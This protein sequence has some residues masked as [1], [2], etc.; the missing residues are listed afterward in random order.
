[1]DNSTLITIALAGVILVPIILMGLRNPMVFFYFSLAA[2]SFLKTPE[3]PYVREKLAA[4]EIGL[5]LVWLFWG[6]IPKSRIEQPSLNAVYRYGGFF[7]LI[8]FLSTGLAVL[9]GSP[10]VAGS[11]LSEKNV[12]Y[13][14]IEAMNYTY[15]VLIVWTT[16]RLLDSWQRWISAILAWMAGMAIASFIGAAAVAG[17]A[18]DWAF[19][20]TGRICSTLK[21]ENQVPSMILPII[22]AVLLTTVRTG[23]NFRYRVFCVL[24]AVAAM[25]TALGTGSRT[26]A[27][28]L[29]LSGLGLYWIIASSAKAGRV[30]DLTLLSGL[31]IAFSA[32]VVFYFWFAWMLYDGQYSLMKTPSWQRP[33]VLLIEWIQGTRDLDSTRP[34]QIKTA[35]EHFWNSPILGTGPKLGGF[36]VEINGE[37]HNTYFSLLLETGILGLGSFL[38]LLGS[39]AL[40]AMVTSRTCPYPWYAILARCLLV[41]LVL[42]GLYNATMLGL[43]QRNIWFLIGLLY[44]FSDLA[45]S[46]S[47]PAS[48]APEPLPRDFG[49]IYLSD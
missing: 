23:L 20:E 22:L 28:M 4:T 16:V 8:C 48:Q 26:A 9:F 17:F 11:E 37:V 47:P 24:L 35:M 19:E 43:R 38:A 14:L 45:V 18:P 12:A 40:R 33:A 10:N 2:T 13:S 1:M 49:P 44:S 31:T 6:M 41:G 39:A 30:I 46:H 42:L 21:N 7:A 36:Y 5:L 25:I 15:G 27:L 29:L 34:A 32:A 3:L